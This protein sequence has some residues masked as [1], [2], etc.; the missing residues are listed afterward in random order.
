[1]QYAAGRIARELGI[2]PAQPVRVALAR[3]REEFNRL[4]GERMPDWALAAALPQKDTIVVDAPRATPATANDM[5]LAIFH[6]AVHLALARAEGKRA[7]RL[8]RWFHE[9]VANWITGQRYLRADRGMFDDA[10]AHGALIPLDRISSTWP[11]AAAEADLAYLESEAFVAHIAAARSPEALRWI[12]DRYRS[13]EDFEKAFSVALGVSR[14]EMEK[15]WAGS[16]RRRFPWLGTLARA[17][18]FWGA[19]AL[20]TVGVF[21]IVRWRAKRQQRR[22]EKEERAWSLV[23]GEEEPSESEKAEDEEPSEDDYGYEDDPPP[24]RFRQAGDEDDYEFS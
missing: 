18:T 5:D 17:I 19:L 9:G 2:P 16:L 15:R 3:G 14:A 20:C 13:G 11:A 4:C 1:V 6:E 10:A 12:L 22:W 7:D 23:L 24:P 21:L 8:P